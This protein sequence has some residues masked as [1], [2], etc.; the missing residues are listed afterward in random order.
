MSRGKFRVLAWQNPTAAPSNRWRQE[1]SSAPRFDLVLRPPAHHGSLFYVDVRLL[2]FN[3]RW[4]AST[5]TPD[6]PSL[7]WDV[8]PLG[9]LWMALEPFDGVIEELLAS[10]SDEV[11]RS[12]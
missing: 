5:D 8:S 12:L 2:E 4:L 9:A 6:G 10:V 11:A 1:L 3:G 7:G